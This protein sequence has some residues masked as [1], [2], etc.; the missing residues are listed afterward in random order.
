MRL[1]YS[2]GKGMAG[3]GSNRVRERKALGLVGKGD[4]FCGFRRIRDRQT[5]G[6]VG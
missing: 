4:A 2:L 3:C 5:V 1:L 6:L